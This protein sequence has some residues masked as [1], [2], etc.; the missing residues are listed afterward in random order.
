MLHQSMC[1]SL[2]VYFRNV[3]RNIQFLSLILIFV[4]NPLLSQNKTIID[5]LITELSNKNLSI[6]NQI[7]LYNKL[8]FEY[9]EID[10]TSSYNYSKKAI[11]K[12]STI[13]DHSGIANAQFWIGWSA[14][15]H[16]N[17]KKANEYY[18]KSLILSKENHYKEGIARAYNG[19][20]AL[21]GKKGNLDKAIVFFKKSLVL[22]KELNDLTG[23][24]NLYSNIGVMHKRKG[25]YEKALKTYFK[26]ADFSA[27][28]KD[29]VGLAK[30]YG[31]IALAYVWLSNY[32][33]A[34]EYNKRAL[35]IFKRYNQTKSVGLVYNNIG[36]I[37][38]NQENYAE[39]L[40]YFIKSYTVKKDLGDK[41][42]LVNQT[43]NIGYVYKMMG[44]IKKALTYY[45]E[46]KQI[47]NE[48]GYQEIIA[49][50]DLSIADC[51][52]LN[53]E[54]DKALEYGFKS[55][56]LAEEKGFKSII[57][58]STCLIGDVYTEQGKYQ[59]ALEYL[60]KG[61][62]LSKDTGEKSLEA[63]AT[64]NIGKIYWKQKKY[65][66]AKEYINKG[67]TLAS[68]INYPSVIRDATKIL[69]ELEKVT[70][71]YKNALESMEVYHSIYDS[72]LGKEKSQQIAQLQ[73]KHDTEKKEQAIVN[74]HQKNTIQAYELKESKLK[75]MIYGGLVVL[76]V[77]LGT[78]FFLIYRQK[79]F[80]LKQQNKEIEQNLLRVQ[81]NPHFIFNAMSAIHDYID[82]GAKV[83]AGQYLVK[84]SK[85]IRQVLDNSRNNFV[86]L[87]EEIKMLDNYLFLQNLRREHPFE[88]K[89]NVSDDI[90]EEEIALPPMFAQPFVE[91]AIEHG[92]ANIKDNATIDVFFTM[93]KDG[94][95][96][97]VKD[98]GEGIKKSTSPKNDNHISHAIKITEERI[99]LFKQMGNKNI[100][101]F[102]ESI[103]SGTSV[104]F[105]LP[106][107]YV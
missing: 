9:S 53:K 46:C 47:S 98:N 40:N 102:V 15:Q 17:Y 13:K 91:N 35:G 16:S 77:L 22:K 39:A 59:D 89:I 83:Q 104:T 48:L 86:T 25:E 4:S 34:M 88:Y 24:G 7:E 26:A 27:Q 61:L 20:G 21:E 103:S 58:S 87:E 97:Q 75:L 52:M 6:K 90:D 57:A 43:N 80:K 78:L 70:G 1:N 96:L 106:F 72:I 29:S 14:M 105:K 31:N 67:I 36:M 85:L 45:E 81:M 28:I 71:N 51:Y 92:L 23:V 94:L 54:Y 50:S 93:K 74:L 69:V 37:F 41:R 76:L 55:Q 5:S 79:Q 3:N 38:A 95:E 42:A 18:E 63:K 12:A 2:E 64:S 32:N 19:F 30:R 100:A 101:F 56:Q 8:A 44:N 82:K 107:K 73:V 11:E 33:S 62:A 99:D 65:H 84:F 10:S 66:L 49:D 60:K 68:K